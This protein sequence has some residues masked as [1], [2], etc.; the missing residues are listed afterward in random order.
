M[1]DHQLD[2]RKRDLDDFESPLTSLDSSPV[3]D[4]LKPLPPA[5]LLLS[6]P[7]LLAVPPNHPFHPESLRL[8]LIALH[9]CLSLESLPPDV[10]CKAWATLAEVG[11]KVIGG[12][13]SQNDRCPWADGVEKEVILRVKP[14][15]TR[16]TNFSGREGYQQRC[17]SR[18][19]PS[20]YVRY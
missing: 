7:T 19:F 1:A 11:M 20:L 8:S 12:G 5:I 18:L 15:N 14:L 13:L 3:R 2:R 9:K 6:L 16:L 17:Q 4:T 10:E